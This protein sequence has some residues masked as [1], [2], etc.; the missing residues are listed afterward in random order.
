MLLDDVGDDDDD[1]ASWVDDGEADQAC[2][3]PSS[4]SVVN[5]SV[6]SKSRILD[7]S[8]T[9]FDARFATTGEYT[10][11]NSSTSS[12]RTAPAASNARRS[13]S[14]VSSLSS[15]RRFLRRCRYSSML[16]LTALSGRSLFDPLPDGPSSGSTSLDLSASLD[17]SVTRSA[18]EMGSVNLTALV[19]SSA[20]V[21]TFIAGP[22]SEESEESSD[23]R[24]IRSRLG[25]RS[26]FGFCFLPTERSSRVSSCRSFSCTRASTSATTFSDASFSDASA[27]SREVVGLSS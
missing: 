15:S 24:R 9:L 26:F 3:C 21:D 6:S 12:D 14:R 16:F 5:E 13:D 17:L 11:S 27:S 25:V 2:G 10:G 19:Q 7:T 4:D 18:A 23:F 20:S 1:E 8:W 22:A